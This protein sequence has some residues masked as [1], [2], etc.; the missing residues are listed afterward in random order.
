MNLGLSTSPAARF[1]MLEATV[2]AK[3]STGLQD[4]PANAILGVG[5]VTI[6]RYLDRPQLV[7]RLKGSELRVDD[8]RLWAEPLKANIL[9][10]IRENLAVLTDAK[11]VYSY[12]Q[13]RSVAVDYQITLDVLRFDADA[14]GRVILKSV[15]RIVEPE[16]RQPVMEMRSTIGQPSSSTAIADVVEAMSMALAELSKEM[17][18]ALV[19]R[20]PR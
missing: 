16:G 10:V 18:Q 20:L 6:P 5:P 8:F 12:P 17:A 11:H 15:W 19:Y 4:G 14:D 2:E 9:R 1:Y 7:S 13:R 3:L